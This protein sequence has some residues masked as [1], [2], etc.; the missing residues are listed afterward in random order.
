MS[1]RFGR[2]HWK[3]FSKEELEVIEKERAEQKQK[4]ETRDSK[5]VYGVVCRACTKPNALTV[6]FCT[7]CGF[8]AT[9]DDIQ[10]L[11]DVNFSF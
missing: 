7:G 10:Q 11:P 4:N 6:N 3:D 5:K 2:S 8:I 9:E 1:F